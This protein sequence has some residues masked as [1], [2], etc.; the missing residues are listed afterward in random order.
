MN[1]KNLQTSA[2]PESPGIYKF[3][4]AEGKI[5]YIGKAINLKNRIKSYF[6]RSHLHPDKTIAMLGKAKY[7]NF[8]K[9]ATEVEALLLE[10]SLIKKYLP[11]YNIILK[12]DKHYLY[13]KISKEEFPRILFSRLTAAKDGSCYGPFPSARVIRDLMKEIRHI[14]PFCTQKESF[15]KP[16]FYSHLGFCNPCPADVK[17]IK[18]RNLYQEQKRKYRNNIRLIRV[19]LNNGF[20]AIT[21][22]LTRE[23]ND[24]SKNL[25]FEQ[26]GHIRD[27]IHKINSLM[28]KHYSS[29][30]YL[31]GQ[32]M[33]KKIYISEQ[34]ELLQILN[35]YYPE[36][37]RISKIECYDISSISGK[38]ATGSLVTF[39]GGQPAKDF[40]RR[41]RIQTLDYPNDFAMLQEVMKRRLRHED[42]PLPDI[43]LIDG[44]RPQLTALQKVLNNYKIDKALIGIAKKFEEL[45][46][47]VNGSFTKVSL[48]KFPSAARLVLRI[49]DEAHRFAHKYHQLLRLKSISDEFGK[50]S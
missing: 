46:I 37:D 36:L 21:Q 44:G 7:L 5:I 18:D 50:Y 24:R 14:F 28:Q 41:F 17:N 43:F 32:Q 1:I 33:I 20:R 29:D 3:S 27:K 31:F 38:Y 16:C 45:V 35:K 30:Y 2:L 15:K 19:L 42:W 11:G 25:D 40:Y 8:L 9:T 12:D 48:G 4:D 22:K 23:M 26:A 10:A 49:R 47:P 13:I 39:I 6:N 34:N